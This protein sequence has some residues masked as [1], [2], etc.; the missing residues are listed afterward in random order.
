ML[1]VIRGEE[2]LL[3]LDEEA[4]RYATTE[5]CLCDYEI[6][7]VGR[8]ERVRFSRGGS[9]IGDVMDQVLVVSVCE[10]LRRIVGDLRQDDR[11]Q[12]T[13]AG[14]SRDGVLGKDGIFVCDAGV[15]K[16]RRWDGGGSHV[17]D[18]VGGV[19]RG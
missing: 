19:K 4:K 5:I 3:D 15:E 16:R 18:T 9:S 14:C 12:A 10:L 11:S 2:A 17:G 1:G 13:C 7:K 8:I 6:G